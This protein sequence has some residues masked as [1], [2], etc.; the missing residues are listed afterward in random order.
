MCLIGKVELIKHFIESEHKFLQ[1]T[2]CIISFDQLVSLQFSPIGP[3]L[4]P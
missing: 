1:E 2:R 3:D 4:M